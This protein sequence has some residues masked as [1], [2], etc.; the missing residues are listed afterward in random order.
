MH[1]PYSFFGRVAN[2]LE[3]TIKP[4]VKIQGSL[5]ELNF[6]INRTAVVVRGKRTNV[7]SFSPS[8]RLRLL[9][10]IAAVK[11]DEIPTGLLVTLTYPDEIAMRT[12]KQRNTDK[13]LFIRL[14]EKHVGKK[15]Y[16]IWRLEFKR[17]K[18]GSLAGLLVPHWHFLLMDIPY[19][20]HRCVRHSWRR[21]TK[22]VGPLATDV[23]ACQNGEMASLY[24]AKYMSKVSP[25]LSL[26]N[27]SYLNMSG[28]HY[29][30][31]RKSLIPMHRSEFFPITD[32]EELQWLMSRGVDLLHW[33]KEGDL[34]SFTLLGKGAT[35]VAKEF[36]EFRLQK[37][38]QAV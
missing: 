16:G 38:R 27:P 7:T 5:L 14:M 8:S 34:Q 23:K 19:I 11:W 17:R 13:Y 15:I 31:L 32:D 25:K 24:I 35:E 26:D 37:R 18:T 21:C 36:L 2:R 20:D 29:G 30:Y 28:R 33:L 22:T 9:K 4:V 10:T 1:S 6:H 12:R 3:T